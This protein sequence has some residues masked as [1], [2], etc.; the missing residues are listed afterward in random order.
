MAQI[1]FNPNQ[2]IQA[3]SGNLGSIAFRTRNGRTY[4]YR[5]EDPVLPKNPTR[6][7]RAKFRQQTIVDYCVTTIQAKIQ[8]IQQALA[9]RITIHNRVVKLYKRLAPTIKARTKLQREIM[10]EYYSR[11]GASESNHSRGFVDPF[12][13]HSRMN[14]KNEQTYD[15]AGNS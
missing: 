7:Q 10:S 4:M 13:N 14:P 12:S 11:F 8:D 15:Y 6:Q 1:T 3:L 5:K 2:P 9:M